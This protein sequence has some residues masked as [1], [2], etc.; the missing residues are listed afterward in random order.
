MLTTWTVSIYRQTHNYNSATT[1]TTAITT[2]TNNYNTGLLLRL[3]HGSLGSEFLRQW[4]MQ[5][6][7]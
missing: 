5:A 1:T 6:D 4:I 2:T 7:D 3:T